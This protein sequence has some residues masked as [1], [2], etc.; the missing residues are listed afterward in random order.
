V[1][2]GDSSRQATRSG[3]FR[4]SASIALLLL[5]VALPAGATTIVEPTDDQLIDRSELIAV[6]SVVSSAPRLAGG[7]IWTDTEISV[8]RTFRGAATS[9]V[10]VRELGGTLGDRATIAFGSPTFSTGERVLLFLDRRDDGTWSTIDLFIGKFIERRTLD[11]ESVWYRPASVRGTHTLAAAAN[12]SEARHPRGFEDYIDASV[13]GAPRSRNYFVDEPRYAKALG[14]DFAL[15][16]DPLVYRW[17][18]FDEGRTVSWVS[19]GRQRGYEQGGLPEIQTA[20][21]SWSGFAD[22]NIRLAYSGAVDAAPRG[23]AEFDGINAIIFN[24]LHNE[25]TGSWNGSSGI[26]GRAS[27]NA[28][29]RNGTWTSP[30]AAD[31]AHPAKTYEE[32]WEIVEGNVVIQDGVS[33]MNSIGS[34]RLAQ[35]IAHE[36]GHTL[37]FAHSHDAAALMAST[38][39]G[40]GPAL[41]HDDQSGARWLYPNAAGQPVA[42]LTISQVFADFA[43]SNEHPSVLDTVTLQDAS[44]GSPSQWQWQFGDGRSSSDRNPSHRFAAPGV[45]TVSLTVVRGSSTSTRT[46]LIRVGP[47]Q[48]FD[49]LVPVAVQTAGA[50]GTDWRTEMS[51][52]N[53]GEAPLVARIT[54]LPSAGGAPLERQ[55][56]LA[57]METIRYE[58]AL[59]E[60]F[61]LA[62]GVGGLLI[63]SSSG[64]G[65][66]SPLRIAS[67]TY[68]TSASGTY[69][70][71]VPG[72]ETLPRV[73]H[74]AGIESSSSFRTNLGFV[75]QAVNDAAAEL[76]LYAADGRELGRA[77]VVLGGHSFQQ[78]AA[79]ALFPQLASSDFRGL[80]L[81]VTA[82]RP[83]AIAAYASVIDNISQDPVLLPATAAAPANQL[84][85][86][87][88]RIAGAAGTFWRTDATLF[89]AEE[90]PMI[91][92]IGRRGSSVRREATIDPHASLAIA[93][94]LQWLEPGTTQATVT[95]DAIG[96]SGPIVSARTYTTRSDG[97]TFGQSIAAQNPD[98]WQAKAILTGLR[99]DGGFRT[100]IGFVNGA[101]TATEI[102]IQLYAGSRAIGSRMV[103][104]AGGGQVQQSIATLFPE[105]ASGAS[106]GLSIRAES[107]T[108]SEFLMFASVIDNASG[109]ATF[110]ASE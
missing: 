103:G 3:G 94:L 16:S 41:R 7:S 89:N 60:L 74:I 32:V 88:A 58:S 53:S 75:N 92:T 6:G 107:K 72:L 12:S 9:R 73:S 85:P 15:L 18:A 71:S 40:S 52:F 34:T 55:I 31:A 69:G 51:L 2:W 100:N 80:S 62:Q 102:E 61:G 54:F 24:D 83:N 86:G 5:A 59:P 28:V 1:A 63:E 25:I 68:T 95:I 78:F 11:G 81:S 27:Y 56:T 46:K 8:E 14:A 96:P 97:G 17:F 10:T 57:P 43:L 29:R 91:V 87:A 108:Y 70:Q 93:D 22:A 20:L 30:F 82:D 47:E 67:R 64:T 90:T 109:D 76:T 65:T 36:I 23:L 99:F 33:P 105:I 110:I 101:E 77:T 26:I 19:Y 4:A 38:I 84:L 98:R 79:A 35:L 44:T 21:A 42:D 104:V 37:G 106:E 66:A 50:G 13:T 48:E 39:D 45:Y 49:T